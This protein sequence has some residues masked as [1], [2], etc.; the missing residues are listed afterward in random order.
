MRPLHGIHFAWL[1]CLATGCASVGNGFGL[2]PS[3]R[4]K[5]LDSTKDLARSMPNAPDIPREL[6]KRVAPPYTVEPGDVLLVQ[7]ADVDSP[8]R[9]SGDQPVL[10]DGTIQL[11]KYGR[12]M[13]AGHTIEEIEVMV[14]EQ[15]SR[16]ARDAGVLI[17]RL[18]NRTSKVYYVVGEVNAPGIFVLNGRETVLDAVLLAGGL[19]DRA[20]PDKVILSRPTAPDSCRIVLPV[21]LREIIQQGDTTT[22]YQLEAGDR[23]FV[24]SRSMWEDHP[25][26]PSRTCPACGPKPGPCVP[27]GIARPCSYGAAPGS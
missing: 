2:F 7:S 14:R 24:P 20:A 21:C 23:V 11:G 26:L 25:W 27:P 6:D 22:N 9:L 12:L 16:Q 3:D 10:P 8:V 1:L 13:V 18:V 15:V 17:V 4:H 5:M 19:T